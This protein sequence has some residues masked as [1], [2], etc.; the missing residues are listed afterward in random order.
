MTTEELEAFTKYLEKTI[1]ERYEKSLERCGNYKALYQESESRA[2]DLARNVLKLTDSN[3]KLT[4]QLAKTKESLEY[5]KKTTVFQ[6]NVINR[7][8]EISP[9]VC[10]L[11]N[12][13]LNEEYALSQTKN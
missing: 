13:I 4:N 11:I 8:R 12:D 5:Y 1:L 7:A 10:T 6:N 9:Q 3:K 2:G